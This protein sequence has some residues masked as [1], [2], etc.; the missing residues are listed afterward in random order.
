M[1]IRTW[2]CNKCEAE[3]KTK[4]HAPTHCEL[5]A[6]ALISTP[7]TKFME[8]QDPHKNKSVM[9]GQEKI[10]RARAREYSRDKELDDLIQRNEHKVSTENRWLTRDGVKRKKIDD[11]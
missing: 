2:K 9:V 5:P 1:A 6:S 11:I 10:L 4:Q 8:K 7:N 3:F